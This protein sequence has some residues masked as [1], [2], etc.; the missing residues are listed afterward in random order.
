MVA[1]SR[2]LNPDCR[3][4]TCVLFRLAVFCFIFWVCAT[5]VSRNKQ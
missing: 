1:Q 5:S 4:I 3:A 2:G